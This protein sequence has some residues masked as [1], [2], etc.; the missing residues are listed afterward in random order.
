MAKV[1]YGDCVADR[2]SLRVR[3]SDL[4]GAGCKLEAVTAGSALDGDVSLWIGAVGPIPATA[5]QHDRAHASLR[6]KEPLNSA[7]LYHFACG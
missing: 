7:I 1:L 5:T 4:A 2:D 3:I 6:F